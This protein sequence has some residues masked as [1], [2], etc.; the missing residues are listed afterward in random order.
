[1]SLCIN[2]QCL[3]P[4]NPDNLLFC[5]A[6]GSELLLNGRYRVVKKLGGGG[7]GKTFTVLDRSGEARV[8]KILTNNHPKAVELFQR[9]ADVLT[10]LLHPGIPK[11]EADGYFVYF[12]RN[13]QTPIHCL[14][15]E[16]IEG[17]DLR[18][19]IYQRG[20]QP[21]DEKLAIAWLNELTQILHQVHA[22][23]F[24]HRDIKPANIMLRV[25]GGLALIDFGTARQITGTYL[26]K[27]AAGGV[28]GI[29]STGYTPPEQIHGQA[30]QQSDFFA[31][32]RT[33]VFLLT[34]TDPAL[35]YDVNTDSLNWR[36]RNRFVSPEFADLI[37]G[38]MARLP[39]HRPTSTEE[40]LQRLQVVAN[41]GQTRLNI[42]PTHLNQPTQLLQDIE[43]QAVQPT[44]I[45]KK[46]H[47]LYQWM[48]A[49]VVGI[50]MGLFLR[51][52]VSAAVYSMVGQYAGFR[53]A[54]LSAVVTVL[55]IE[56]MQWMALHK[57]ISWDF[58]SIAEISLAVLIGLVM[59][60]AIG[61]VLLL[62]MGQLIGSILGI[63]TATAIAKWFILRGQLKRTF[64]WLMMS[65][66][67]IPTSLIMGVITGLLSYWLLLQIWLPSSSLTVSFAMGIAVSGFFWSSMSGIAI[68]I[69]LRHRKV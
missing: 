56:M 27:Q 69:L 23:N 3:Q 58:W 66:V 13:S 38:M 1:M 54:M 14:V 63:F 4:R 67:A 39:Q 7:F 28:T 68:A 46:R 51:S 44:I 21:I 36:D 34:A 22:Q 37:D 60:T 49:S 30:V 43:L 20:N 10:H 40:I 42:A 47:F 65:M 32:A 26:A 18:E 53:Y 64:L 2:P 17:L 31:L 57:R 55:P 48:L 12:P 19:Y 62:E 29:V 52:L 35:L 61:R 33:F 9:E 5:Q 16:Q 41:Q 11:V 59:G 45:Q 50:G 25:D 6:C 15:M 8:L 24:F